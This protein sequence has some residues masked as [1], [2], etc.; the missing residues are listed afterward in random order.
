MRRLAEK[1]CDL[2]VSDLRLDE[3]TELTDLLPDVLRLRPGLPVIIITAFGTLDS[4]VKAM[5][6]GAF[7]YI[8]KPFPL[9]ALTMAVRRALEHREL[10][11]EVKELR[12]RLGEVGEAGVQLLGRSPVDRPPARDDPAAR[13]LERQPPHH[14]RERG[15]EGS[16]GAHRPSH[17][18]AQPG[19]LPADQLR[20]DPGDAARERALRPCARRLHRRRRRAARPLRRGRWRDGLPRR[21]RGDG[22]GPSG[23]ALAGAA[24]RRGAAA[25][26]DP[27]DQ[28]RRADHRRHE[29]RSRGG[30]GGGAA[31]PGP[32]LPAGRRPSRGAAAP[33]SARGHPASRRGS[34]GA[35]PPP[36]TGGSRRSSRRKCGGCCSSTRGRGTCA[37]WTTSSGMRWRS[38]RGTSSESASSRRASAAIASSGRSSAAPRPRG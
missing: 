17:E 19:S 13:G 30:N 37:S 11:H 22:A 35:R 32:L 15:G 2:V 38:R 18:P 7:D 21:D 10:E 24:G 28:R 26:P 9:E 23:E 31:A 6:L 1:S 34:D 8:T 20:R 33:R 4:A 16:G 25:R 29:P 12:R 27:G 14:R 36:S 3:T 5:K